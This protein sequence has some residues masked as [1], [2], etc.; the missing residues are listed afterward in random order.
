LDEKLT[1]LVSNPKKLLKPKGYLK[2]NFASVGKVYQPRVTQDNVKVPSEEIT[3]KEIFKQFHS[4]E[5]ST[6]KPRVK[7]ETLEVIIPEIKFEID[8]T[9]PVSLIDN[10]T[11]ENK[12]SLS[13]PTIINT[14][15]IL[16]FPEEKVFVSRNPK[17]YFLYLDSSPIVS[18]IYT[19]G[20]P[21]ETSSSFPFPPHLY[22]SY[23]HDIF[24]K[25]HSQHL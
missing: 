13:I 5:H 21:E 8:W 6:S 4:I 18:P 20:K 16:S 19:S 12:R 3:P 25:L 11:S 1:T 2:Q 9:I 14:Q 15:P 7:R 10:F 23:P 24:P 22:L 17:D